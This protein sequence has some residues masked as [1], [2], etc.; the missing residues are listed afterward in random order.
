MNKETFVKELNSRGINCDE[1]QLNLLW[2][3]MRHDL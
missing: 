2:D 1:S 3:F